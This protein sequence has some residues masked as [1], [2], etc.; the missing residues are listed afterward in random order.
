MAKRKTKYDSSYPVTPKPK[1]I[2]L[3]IQHYA[4]KET[5]LTGITTN[6]H[7]EQ[8]HYNIVLKDEK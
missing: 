7:G 5:P 8:I 2:T 1:G 4:G 6:A 3:N